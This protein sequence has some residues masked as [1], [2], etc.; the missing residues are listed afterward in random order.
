MRKTLTTSYN[1][2][3]LPELVSW[4]IQGL[5]K[6]DLSFQRKACWT[7]GTPASYV[8]GVL[9]GQPSGAIILADVESGI[10]SYFEKLRAEGK[11]KYVSIDGNNRTTNLSR[12]MGNEFN[13]DTAKADPEDESQKVK[14]ENLPE[15]L[16]EVFDNQVMCVSI[17]HNAT[18]AN[19]RD[20]F[21]SH[22]EG[23]GPS[24]Q[25]KRN[26]KLGVLAT[27]V[28][29]FES[30]I[31][32]NMFDE[33]TFHTKDNNKRINDKENVGLLCIL[34]DY[35]TAPKEDRLK[36]YW[37]NE[38]KTANG[39]D[40]YKK[41]IT[42]Y[43]PGYLKKQNFSN[44]NTKQSMQALVDLF[45]GL[46]IM[47]TGGREY[48]VE[49][50]KKAINTIGDERKK[51]FASEDEILFSKGKI[52][53][54]Q[55]V[56]GQYKYEVAQW[57][58]RIAMMKKIVDEML[59]GEEVFVYTDRDTTYNTMETRR[60]L[61]KEQKGKCPLSGDDISDTWVNG[62]ETEVDH[63]D[64]VRESGVNDISNL[65]LVATKAHKNKESLMQEH[66]DRLIKEHTS[67][68][69]SINAF[70]SKRVA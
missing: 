51:L 22:N 15:N 62:D 36:E 66:Y 8:E 13:I 53:Y 18:N 70:I 50:L 23:Q 17:M 6:H 41:L 44:R 29:E 11:Y 40:F 56:G 34:N 46:G 26:A 69:D 19:C 61:V 68:V 60:K 32:T 52:T 58:Y 31:T 55:L 67:K 28:R 30:Y 35:K 7:K 14:Y 20:A 1:P 25:E 33:V 65:W 21:I 57:E 27:K 38:L 37:D 59:K 63:I 45:I 43:V 5:I 42:K 3:T 49:S 64:E 16:K 39:F 54:C 12:F 9:R 47:Y 10:G 2:T 48:S 24:A 4:F